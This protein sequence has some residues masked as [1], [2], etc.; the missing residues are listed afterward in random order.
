MIG[1]P[2]FCIGFRP[3]E[4]T[5]RCLCG[6]GE[7]WHRGGI[8]YEEKAER[9]PHVRERECSLLAGKETM[10][11]FTPPEDRPQDCPECGRPL[12]WTPA[13]EVLS[14]SGGWSTWENG[15]LTPPDC[16]YYYDPHGSSP[17][18]AS[19]RLTGDP[20]SWPPEVFGE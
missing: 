5:G 2:C 20:S 19:V 14:C 13:T 4:A 11:M 7:D 16:T 12:K 3:N 6:D 18:G 9:L 10:P 1:A 15:K 17:A 8:R